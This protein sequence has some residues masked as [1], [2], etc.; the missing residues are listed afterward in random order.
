MYDR[1]DFD[2]HKNGCRKLYNTV[3]LTQ[4]PV[5]NRPGLKFIYNL[6]SIGLDPAN[7]KVRT[8]P[9]IASETQAYV[10]IFFQHTSGEVRLV[11]GTRNGLVAFSATPPA[12]CPPGTPRSYT[13]GQ[14]VYL[15]M[16]TGWDILNFDWAQSSDELYFAQS[17]LHPHSIKRYSHECW[18]IT[19]LYP[20]FTSP[21]SDW[22]DVNGWPQKVTFHQQRVAFANITLRPQTVWL[23][24][25][26]DFSHFG[27]L[28]TDIVDADAVTFTLNSGTQ[29][30]IKWIAS[31]KTLHVGT[32]GDEWTVQG[33]KQPALTPSDIL[34]QRQTKNGSEA[35]KPLIIGLTTLFIER[36]GRRI[37]EFVY[38]YT[39]DSYKTSDL[40]VLS[41]HVTEFYSVIDWGYQQIPDSIIWGV[42]ADGDLLGLTYQREHKVV[43]WHHHD[44]QGAFKTVSVIPGD[45]R[46]DDVFFVVK[47]IVE[48]QDRYYFEMMEDFFNAE[49]AEWGRFLDSHLIYQ[50]TPAN[51]I[52]G[53]DHL[54]GQTVGVLV[55]G[56][57]HPD[58]VVNNSGQIV[59]NDRYAHVVGGLKYVSEFRPCLPDASSRTL[60]TALGLVGRIT[61]LV[62]D[63][64]RTVGC[65]VGLVNAE[66]EEVLE[67]IPFRYPW[68]PTDEQI[69]LFSGWRKIDFLE[70]YGN[71][72]DYFIRQTQPLPFTIRAVVDDIEVED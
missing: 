48:G 9:F 28:G 15:T 67:E 32:M 56:M 21:P 24:R 55:D 51:I 39:Y 62:V 38:D 6:N 1:I 22:S 35:N 12:Q 5:T 49:E 47:R 11:F 16:P 8:I 30:R 33:S 42:R 27:K 19:D 52:S 59:L 69:P 63:F 70:G 53:Y 54:K 34:A 37:N 26:G 2:R 3:C 23:S 65:T 66:G 50:G 31:G 41:P 14:I 10:L 18:A 44:T 25:A 40:S 60:P 72:P 61:D 58:V 71:T 45:T 68:F 13:P 57:V 4:G 46:E 36:H 17:G 29:N 7:P 43:G 20:S 64:Y